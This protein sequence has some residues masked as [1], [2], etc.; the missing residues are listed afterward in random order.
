MDK[1]LSVYS[2]ALVSGQST[3]AAGVD[4]SGCLIVKQIFNDVQKSYDA[5]QAKVGFSPGYPAK[6]PEPSISKEEVERLWNPV[7]KQ[8]YTK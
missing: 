1:Y 2:D 3:A 7:F 5:A 4:S 6:W 8:W